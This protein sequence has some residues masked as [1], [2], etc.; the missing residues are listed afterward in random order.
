MRLMQIWCANDAGA[1]SKCA[2]LGPA[3]ARLCFDVE[4]GGAYTG[5]YSV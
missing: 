4:R 2:D 3:M 5:G 1:P